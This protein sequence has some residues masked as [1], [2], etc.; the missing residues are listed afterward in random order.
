MAILWDCY[1]IEKET[2]ELND[3]TAQLSK[4][5]KGAEHFRQKERHTPKERNLKK[6]FP[7]L[8]TSVPTATL[9]KHV[10]KT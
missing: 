7:S 1:W 3:K 9:A 2:F 4:K 5:T 10:G 8:L 6:L